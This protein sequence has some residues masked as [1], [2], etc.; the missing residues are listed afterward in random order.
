MGGSRRLTPA[1]APRPRPSLG[2]HRALRAQGSRRPAAP[3]ARRPGTPGKAAHTACTAALCP[4]GRSKRWVRQTG[5][6][7]GAGGGAGA[8]L[9]PLA[10]REGAGQTALPLPRWSRA[11]CT[12]RNL[13][14][15]PHS[16]PAA[17]A[18]VT[19]GFCVAWHTPSRSAARCEEEPCPRGHPGG[20]A[21]AAAQAARQR[22]L[23]AGP[24]KAHGPRAAR[25]SCTAACPAALGLR[26]HVSQD[27][28]PWRGAGAAAPPGC[29]HRG[30]P[31]AVRNHRKALALA[32]GERTAA[33]DSKATARRAAGRAA[34]AVA[35]TTKLPNQSWGLTGRPTCGA[36][37]GAT[38]RPR[39][40][41]KSGSH[42]PHPEW[43]RRARPVSNR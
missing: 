41:A 21:P 33:A 38:S 29:L 39:G 27:T 14:P 8:S 40:P 22:Q 4:G 18:R 6:N 9:R 23:L 16:L 2:A 37:D 42:S 36:R 10:K 32:R 5:T 28:T 7:P 3:S 1:R 15:V 30:A 24:S 12:A 31:H 25:T 13:C 43:R 11:P 17:A 26:R 19:G 20:C 35:S 34:A